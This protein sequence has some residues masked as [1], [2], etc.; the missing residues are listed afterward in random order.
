MKRISMLMLILSVLCLTAS[1][2]DVPEMPT[3]YL[4][5]QTALATNPASACNKG[6]ESFISFIKQFKASQKFR[7]SRMKIDSS[8]FSV[9]PEFATYILEGYK[10]KTGRTRTRTEKWFGTYYN[11]TADQVWYCQTSEPVSADAEWGGG[12]EIYGF[13]RIGGKWY[14]VFVQAAG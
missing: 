6:G 12:S 8:T 5:K 11:V 7:V 4:T 13:Q 3:G 10:G 9:E 14:V 1:A 2:L